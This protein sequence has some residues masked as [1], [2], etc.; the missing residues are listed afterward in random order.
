MCRCVPTRGRVVSSPRPAPVAAP[1]ARPGRRGRHQAGAGGEGHRCQAVHRRPCELPP[2]SS[3][4]ITTLLSRPRQP[5]R[6]PSTEA[7]RSLW[8]N[9]DRT[10]A[11]VAGGQQRATRWYDPL[12]RCGMN[13]PATTACGTRRL[14]LVQTCMSQR[15]IGPAEEGTN[16]PSLA[17]F[18]S[19]AS[20]H[21]S[22]T[23][24]GWPSCSTGTARSSW[25]RRSTKPAP[26]STVEHR[27]TGPTL[28]RCSGDGAVAPLAASDSS[29]PI[30]SRSLRRVARDT[31]S[32][33]RHADAA[34]ARLLVCSPH[35][36]PPHVDPRRAAQGRLAQRPQRRWARRHL[37]RRQAAAPQARRDRRADDD[38]RDP[39]PWL[40]LGES[41]EQRGLE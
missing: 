33:P 6:M 16:T 20:P 26:S 27:V 2:Q 39:R 41:A 32:A 30:R 24:S 4:P 23:A 18:L 7:T 17:A 3:S 10:W 40:R 37:L 21:R 11:S 22:T 9:K 36:A 1:G 19:S 38:R 29:D 14:L 31:R 8:R 13:L 35:R 25:P 5:S 15:R 28:E 12:W 34:R